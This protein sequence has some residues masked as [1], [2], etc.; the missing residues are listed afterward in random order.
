MTGLITPDA[1]LRI[2]QAMPPMPSKAEQLRLASLQFALNMPRP[3]GV[4]YATG[5]ELVTAAERIL[6]YINTGN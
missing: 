4:G 3:E 2:P 1:D 5:N 6:R